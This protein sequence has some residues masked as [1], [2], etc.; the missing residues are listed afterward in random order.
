MARGIGAGKCVLDRCGDR[1]VWFCSRAGA[2]VVAD[3]PEGSGVAGERCAMG[4]SDGV[5]EKGTLFRVGYQVLSFFEFDGWDRWGR[6]LMSYLPGGSVY[7]LC[8]WEVATEVHGYA[9]RRVT[10][11]LFAVCGSNSSFEGLCDKLRRLGHWLGDQSLD[12]DLTISSRADQC[13]CLKEWKNGL[14]GESVGCQV[15]W[16]GDFSDVEREVKDFVG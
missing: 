6:D 4:G 13:W 10:G 1:L 3:A 14:D 7:A 12:V 2:V 15:K 11:Y 16:N 8:G 9:G 5:V